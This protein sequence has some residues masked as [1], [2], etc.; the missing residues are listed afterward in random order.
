MARISTE[1]RQ[2]HIVDEAV[3]IIHEKGYQSLSI[4]EL[5]DRVGISEPAIYRHFLNKEDIILGILGRFAEFD[6]QLLAKIKSFEEPI[7]RISQ[8]INFHFTFL[9]RNPELTSVLF[10]E[11]VFS[12]SVFLKEKM[13]MIIGKRKRIL[14]EILEDGKRTDQITDIDINELLTLILGFIRL[15]VL[16][17]RLSNFSFSLLERGKKAAQVIEKLIST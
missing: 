13:M 1:E 15:I 16:E 11:D 3:K 9:E 4:R 8:F 2:K 6:T 7:E 14:K 17:W 5:S 10:S 12:Q